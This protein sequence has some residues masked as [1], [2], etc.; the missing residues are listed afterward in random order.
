M[1]HYVNQPCIFNHQ[2]TSKMQN[3]ATKSIPQS[4]SSFSQQLLGILTKFYTLVISTHL[5]KRASS[6]WYSSTAVKLQTLSY[7]DFAHSI[8]CYNEYHVLKTT[9]SILLLVTSK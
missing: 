3:V 8:T 2:A 6:I 7:R 1:T 4:C 9:W 5:Q